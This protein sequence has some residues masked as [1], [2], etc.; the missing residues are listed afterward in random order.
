M[1]VLLLLIFISF[2]F[3]LGFAVLYAFSIRNH[4]LH[5]TDQLSLLPLEDHHDHTDTYDS[6]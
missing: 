6:L 2:M 1:N 4:D 3:V 5:H